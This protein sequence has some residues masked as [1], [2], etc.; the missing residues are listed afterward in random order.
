VSDPEK[1]L[2]VDKNISGA[3][4]SWNPAGSEIY[5]GGWLVQSDGNALEQLLPEA[6]ESAGI[7][8]PDGTG[9]A[10]LYGNNLLYFDGFLPTFHAGDRPM[11]ER[12][13]QTRNKLRLLKTLLKEKLI[14]EEEFKMRRARLLANMGMEKK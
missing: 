3:F 4:P 9:L 10:I 14:S 5:I 11:D 13:I 2:T 12:M 6:H 1:S 8:S 7:W